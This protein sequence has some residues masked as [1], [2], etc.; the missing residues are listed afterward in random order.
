[1]AL[2]GGLAALA[3]AATLG[4]AP[5]SVAEIATYRGGDR[6]AML[7]AGARP[8]GLVTLYATGT[9][10]RPLLDRFTQKH[11]YLRV[12]TYNAGTNEVAIKA[13]QEYAAQRY[14]VDGFELDA[15]GI[16]AMK[17]QGLIQPFWSPQLAAYPATALE[18]GGNWVIVRESYVGLGY[19]TSLVRAQDAPR[20]Y[21]DLLDPRWKGKLAING[22]LSTVAPW[23][24]ALEQSAGADFPRALAAQDVRVY[25]VTSRALANLIVSGEVALSPTIY[26]SHVEASRRTGAPI[27]WRALGPCYTEQ[28]AVALAAHAPHPHAMLLLA[29]FLLSSEGQR[30]YRDLGYGT[31]RRDVPS[32][33]AQVQ[34]MYLWER[35]TY[36]S[37]F[38]EWAGVYQQL[39]LK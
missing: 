11:P 39:F 20:T 31:T 18:A 1:M 24:G 30:M 6:Q 12:Q 14:A 7:E 23:I 16:L 2:R 34:K 22:T 27:A 9:Q 26:S 3:G 15:A 37:D 21:R 17:N 8:E 5:P 25:Q 29:D 19:N 38:K 36:F 33:T 28:T 32:R 35:P 13:M 4:T 10:L